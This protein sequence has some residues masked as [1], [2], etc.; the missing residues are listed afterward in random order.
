MNSLLANPETATLIQGLKPHLGQQGAVLADG[1]LAVINFA[2]SSMGRDIL[3]TITQISST[4]NQQGKSFTVQ[5]T[6]GPLNIA[7]NL[8]FV[9]FLVFVLLMFSQN[10]MVSGSRN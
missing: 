5:T 6:D 10:P 7:L 1:M 3:K 9:M 4:V 2:T 8:P